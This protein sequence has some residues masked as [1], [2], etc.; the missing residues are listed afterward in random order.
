MPSWSE[1]L[2]WSDERAKEIEVRSQVA[3]YKLRFTSYHGHTYQGAIKMRRP[4]VPLNR[5]GICRRPVSVAI[6]IA[7]MIHQSVAVQEAL[8]LL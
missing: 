4:F 2:K 1:K 3:I 8:V 6:T 7:D 5:F